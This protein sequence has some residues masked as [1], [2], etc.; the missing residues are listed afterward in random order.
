MSRR[1]TTEGFIIDAKRVHG[2]KYDY[3]KVEYINNSTKVCIICPVHGEFWQTP[4]KHLEGRGC[5][6]CSGRY[7]TTDYFIFLSKQIFGERYDYSKTNYVDSEKPVIIT[8]RKHGDFI[9][10]PTKHINDEQGCKKCAIEYKKQKHTLSQEEYINRCFNVH[11]ELYDLSEVK[12]I[13]LVNN[14][15]PICHKHG[16]FSLRADCFL[17]GQGCPECSRKYSNLENIV[18]RYCEIN[19]VNFVYQK[20]YDWLGLL[21]LDFYLPEYN[22]AIEC[23][24][25]QHYKPCGYFGGDRKLFEQSERDIRKSKLCKEHGISIY[26]FT[27]KRFIKYQP[28]AYYK[29]ED[30]FNDIQTNV[31]NELKLC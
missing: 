29:V 25:L 21:S 30:L 2:D 31:K 4:N 11:G 24:G 12:Y 13:G 20:R 6:K 16:V 5:P 26:Y 14:I 19:D 22:V 7:R 1:K 23:Q 8:C 10:K 18:L 28:E 15:T 9:I 3:S 27:E 17:K